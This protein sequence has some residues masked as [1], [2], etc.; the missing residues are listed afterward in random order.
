MTHSLLTHDKVH[1]YTFVWGSSVAN[2]TKLR[3]AVVIKSIYVI[4]RCICIKYDMKHQALTYYIRTT[5]EYFD[6]NT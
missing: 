4:V 5:D 3:T 1:L 6:C 2:D